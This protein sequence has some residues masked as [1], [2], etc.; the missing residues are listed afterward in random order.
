ML[1]RYLERTPDDLE[2]IVRLGETSFHLGD[3]ITSNLYLNNAI[4]A[5][6]RPKTNLERR[7]A[8]NYSLLGDTVGMMKVLSYLVQER[9]AS[10][11]DF[12]VAISLALSE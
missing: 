2:T 1:L 11:D 6:Y 3:Y 9:D 8:Y 10:E 5:G 7:L 4:L 12:A